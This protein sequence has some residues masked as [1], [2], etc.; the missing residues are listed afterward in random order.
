M[1][2]ECAALAAVLA[3]PYWAERAV[4]TLDKQHKLFYQHILTV[5]GLDDERTR[6]GLSMTD[7]GPLADEIHDQA[8][9]GRILT[10][11]DY[12]AP[13]PDGVGPRRIPYIDITDD[14]SVKRRFV[15]MHSLCD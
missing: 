14:G 5:L 9:W 11:E 15:L 4:P 12:G 1:H 2:P 7:F 6:P 13:Y 10:N 3:S 8:R